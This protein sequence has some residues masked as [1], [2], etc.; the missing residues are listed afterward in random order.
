MQLIRLSILLKL[1]STSLQQLN[2][3]KL[4]VPLTIDANITSLSG[5]IGS[6]FLSK[7]FLGDLI[8]SENSKNILFDELDDDRNGLISMNEL[9]EV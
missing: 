2:A 4:L 7:D 3:I 6:G 5:G 9:K 8:T 1:S